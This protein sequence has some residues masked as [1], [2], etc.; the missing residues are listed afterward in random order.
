MLVVLFFKCAFSTCLVKDNQID[1]QRIQKVFF[2]CLFNFDFVY[3]IKRLQ[4]N[5]LTPIL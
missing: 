1:K 3:Y 2:F 4:E 5:M